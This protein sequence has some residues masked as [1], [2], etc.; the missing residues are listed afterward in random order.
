MFERLGFGS[1]QRRGGNGVPARQ[2][3]LRFGLAMERP[4]LG[5][6]AGRGPGPVRGRDA[7]DGEDEIGYHRG[8]SGDFFL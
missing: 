3:S 7:D 2:F 5:L 4:G 1:L 6:G 8:L